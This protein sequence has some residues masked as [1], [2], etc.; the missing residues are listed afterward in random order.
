[1][2][3]FEISSKKPVRIPRVDRLTTK[4]RGLLMVLILEAL[5]ARHDFVDAPR[6]KLQAPHNKQPF[7]EH[8]TMWGGPRMPAFTHTE[9]LPPVASGSINS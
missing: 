2:K 7:S 6:G 5:E 3:T 4:H 8:S 1:M 9:S